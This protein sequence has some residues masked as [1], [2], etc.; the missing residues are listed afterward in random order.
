MFEVNSKKLF[1]RLFQRKHNWL[2]PALINYE[3]IAADLTCHMSELATNKF[4]ID[5][6]TIDTYEEIIG[7]FRLP[8][9]KDLA[10]Q[11]HILNPAQTVKLRSDL[12]KTILQHFKTQKGL[13]FGGAKSTQPAG[14]INQ[15]FMT[16]CKKLLGK[17][18]K[19][20]T[21]SRGV[22]VRILMLY[23]LSSTYH[24]DANGTESGQKQL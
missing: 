6:S 10:K 4:L 16:Q 15:K 20:D 8:E 11:F 17:C 5:E 1:V 9:L 14:G 2:K 19:L 22:F 24:S 18:Y 3:H 12:V 7:L 13:Q 21:E 23:N